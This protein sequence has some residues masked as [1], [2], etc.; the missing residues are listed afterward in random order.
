MDAKKE[1]ILIKIDKG[2]DPGRTDKFLAE[3]Y[4][5]R[6]RVWWKNRIE[7]GCIFVNGRAVKATYK[8]KSGD[9]LSIMPETGSEKEK[10]AE[11][12]YETPKID[13]VY[14]D[15]DAIVLDKPAGLPV[16]GAATYKGPTVVDFLL[17][18][19]PEIINVGE[20]RIR[21]GI[22]HRLDKDTS[23]LLIV[24]K[25][26]GSFRFLKNQ[27]KNRLAKKTYA[28]LVYGNV[29]ENEGAIDF[30]IGRSKSDPKMQTA[31]DSK[32]KEDIRSREAL[33][34]YKVI[35]RF[36]KYTLIEAEPKTGRMHQ[37]RVHLKAIGH[38]VVGDKKYFSRKYPVIQPK[39]GRQ[40][41]HAAKLE[42]ELP[43]AGKK[44][45]TSKIPQDLAEFLEKIS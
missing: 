30:R 9:E 6:S 3:K 8:L 23:G 44:T 28:T 43:T 11:Q 7:N 24:A 32:K 14:E 10:V 25:N 41:L 38:P 1:N 42:I 4:P 20:D 17:H 29:P 39:P 35:K 2:F 27:F 19:F 18:S 33:T 15:R 12:E 34:L 26:D 45:F 5:E 37:I 40:F 22:V 31:I 36:D 16:H 21:P 13:I